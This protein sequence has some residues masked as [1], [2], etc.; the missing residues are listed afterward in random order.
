MMKRVRVIAVCLTIAFVMGALA[1]SA[2]AAAPE[3]G[4]CLKT[5]EGGGTKYNSAKCTVVASGEKE[6]FEWYPAFGESKPLEKA[7]FTTALKAETLAS[8]TSIL[9]TKFVCKT[10]MSGGKYT[11]EQTVGGIVLQFTACES[12]GGKC[13]SAG[14]GVGQ[15]SW[16]E[17]N[18]V[19]G[20]WKTGETQVK[21][22]LGISLKPNT[23]E[24]LVEFSCG[25][26]I[27][28]VRGSVILPVTANAMKLSSTVKFN[29]YK[30]KQKPEQFVGGPKEVLECKFASAAYE[31]CGLM[32]AMI[33]TNEEKVEASTI[34]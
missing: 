28:K 17:L 29:S 15:I 22:K 13:N 34:L 16:N 4:R 12:G 10:E 18:G 30:G 31:Q 27:V 21:D 19:L 24:E 5:K 25:G 20:V 9:G 7:G 2:S 33:W 26:L 32:L 3:F 11:G 23:G 6:N 8:L 1:T 14:K